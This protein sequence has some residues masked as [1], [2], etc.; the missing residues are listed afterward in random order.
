MSFLDISTT[1]SDDVVQSN[2]LNSISIFFLQNWDEQNAP[3]KY[4]GIFR[5]RLWIKGKFYEV[6]VD[7]RLPTVGN[8]LLFCQSTSTNEFW[9]ALLE[10]ACAKYVCVS[11][12]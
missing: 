7:D 2:P 1:I 11:I 12:C 3:Q 4:V 9:C 8:H 5:F 6:V 10:K